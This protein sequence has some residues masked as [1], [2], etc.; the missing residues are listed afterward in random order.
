MD[1]SAWLGAKDAERCRFRREWKF[2]QH[3]SGEEHE[4][5]YGVGHGYC[6][7]YVLS[8]RTEP[9]TLYNLY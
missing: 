3:E 6:R 2:E 1:E 8:A 7:Q 4:C 5:Q 9:N